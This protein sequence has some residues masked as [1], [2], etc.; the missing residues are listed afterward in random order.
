LKDIF[1]IYNIWCDIK[2][3]KN[4]IKTHIKF[5][6][7]FEKLNYKQSQTKGV[8]INNKSGKR[9]YNLMVSL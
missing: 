1:K 6:E 9:G 2:N 3:I 8:D 7:E 4:S 5:K